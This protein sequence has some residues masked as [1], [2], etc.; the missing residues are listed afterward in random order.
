MQILEIDFNGK[1]G[2][3]WCETA[4]QIFNLKILCEKYREH[5]QDLYHVFIDYK[6]AFDRVWHDALW[7]TMNLYNMNSNLIHVIQR[8]YEKASS[9]VFFNGNIG[10][11]FNVNVGVRQGC[12][13][14]PTLFNIFLERI[15]SEA[16]ECHDGSVSIGGRK[17]TNLRFADD[18]L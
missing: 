6:K 11:W 17:I 1:L 9:A 18:R 8:L 5:Q 3:I 15:M 14:S 16:L 13:L 2:F 4:E 12:L 10:E 7:A